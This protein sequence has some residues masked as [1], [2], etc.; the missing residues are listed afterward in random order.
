MHV[1]SLVPAEGAF[2]DQI[3]DATFDI[4]HER[5]SRHAYGRYY[6]AQRRTAWG[7]A[8]LDR[9][10]LVDRDTVLASAKRYLFDA[11]LDGR[12]IRAVG[13]GAVFTQPA[14]RGRGVARELVE[15]ILEAAT[16]AGIDLAVLFSEIAPEYYM[17]LGFTAIDTHDIQLRV[18]ESLRHGAPMAMIRGGDDRD[19]ADIVAMGGIRAQPFRF[20]L[21]R[22]R[23]LVQ[24]AVAKRRLLA[25]LGPP[26]AREVQFFVAE[27]G[28]SAVAYAVIDRQQDE[29]TIE[30]C[31]DRDPTGARLGAMLQ[32]LIARD[33]A[34]RRP[35]IRASLPAGFVPPQVSVIDTTPSRDVMMVR[36]LSDRAAAARSLRREDLLYWPSDRF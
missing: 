35:V 17:R 22:D 2:L 18:T 34:E 21:D 27:E 3:L 31:G 30:E 29:W 13:L 28:A 5:L 16:T 19:L 33:P 20:H 11:T 36:A 7:C 8:H 23:D 6:E 32:V 24:Y 1:L 12:S 26:G 15:R 25:G 14:Y 10:A 9:V 4:W